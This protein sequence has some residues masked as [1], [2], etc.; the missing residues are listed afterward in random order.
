VGVRVN[1]RRRLA[2]GSAILVAA[3]VP[4]QPLSASSTLLASLETPLVADPSYF[5]PVMVGGKTFPVARSN[6]LSLIEINNNWHALRLRMVN[7][8]WVPIG[9]HEGIDISGE[10]GTPI[11]CMEPGVVENVGWTFYSGTRVGVRGVDGRYYF[12]AHLSAVASG[13]TLGAHVVTGQMLGRLGNT[14]Y[15]PPG[16]RDQFPP[17]LHFG[18]Q[19]GIRWVDPYRTLVSLYDAAVK[20]DTRAQATLDALA[21]AGKRS[22]WEREASDLFTTFGP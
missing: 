3:L 19:V 2:V 22:S 11:L 8:K 1:R 14:G 13:V 20:A 6:Y 7:G 15:G 21:A 18:I 16:E 9:V 12:Y 5:R 4:S 10:R 17:H